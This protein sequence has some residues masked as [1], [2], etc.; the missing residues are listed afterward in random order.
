MGSSSLTQTAHAN[1]GPNRS[2]RLRYANAEDLPSFPSSGLK[3]DGAAAS[4]AASLGWANSKSP[5]LPK[6]HTTSS[7]A[8]AAALLAND[9]KMGPPRDRDP[10]HGQ[11]SS[12][13]S[14]AAILAAGSAN[15]HQHR[16]SEPPSLWGS[17]AAN[18]A[19]K[20]NKTPPPPPTETPTLTQNGS[21]HAAK[22]AMA[23]SRP[24]ALSSPQTPRDLYPDQENA[25]ANALSAATIA[26]RPSMRTSTNPIG[27]AGA[28]PWT[29]M[30][31]QMFTSHPPVKLEVDEQ[32]RSDVIHASAVAM[33]KQMYTQQQKTINNTTRARRSSSFTRQGHGGPANPS[34]EEQQAS[35][36]FGTLQ[37]AAY[38]LAQER[39]AK[40]H[41]E[42]QKSRDYEE[43]YG[44]PGIPQRSKF[45]SIRGK[46]TRRRSASDGDLIEDQRR[47]QQIRQQMSLFNTKVTEVDEQKRTRDRE[48]LLA[49]A[50]R[51][52][53]AQMK[54]MDDK[55]Q[56]ETGRIGSSNMG[57]WE[58][59][60]HAAAQARFDASRIESSRK[61]DIG[62]GKFM[63]KDEVDKIAA[64]RI[65]PLLD[66]INE[67]A[68]RER[69]KIALLKLEEEK[70]K[71]EA[72]RL[73]MREREV[74][75]IHRKLKEQQKDDEKARQAEI[76]QAEKT[77]KEEEKAA[78]AEQKRIA[79][80]AK[81]KDKEAEVSI[82]AAAE[83]ETEAVTK[84]VTDKEASPDNS[85]ETTDIP[86][87][88]VTNEAPA[89][90]GGRSH[91]LS[92]AFPKLQKH[93]HK[94]TPDKAS[95]TS[96][97]EQQTIS[98]TSKV[99]S[100]LKTR[101][102]RPR[103]KSSPVPV[104]PTK[105]ND[106]ELSSKNAE[107]GFIGGV[108]LAKKLN[109]SASSLQ[110]NSETASI[111][112]VAMAGRDEPGESSAAAAR[113]VSPEERDVTRAAAESVSSMSSNNSSSSSLDN[114][115]EARSDLGSGPLTPPRAVL[116][117]P[118]ASV[119]SGRRSPFRESRFSENLE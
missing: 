74:Q 72:E 116:K 108:A 64:Q 28:V 94:D 96:E 7:S 44:S 89:T 37:E 98:P 31:R 79:K 68:E 2:G 54:T 76:K 71:E 43:Y 11:R 19:F 29:T 77:R 30:D 114:F 101:F 63:D 95:P 97:D 25:T 23:G 60:A 78:K 13:G 84:P 86:E 15:R 85:Q 39:L 99:K 110:N 3:K 32:R 92:I 65:Q 41:D 113:P 87:P 48:T 67:K 5:E 51:N 105:N 35:A 82:P 4:V 24:R 34:N 8:S 46:L 50:Q 6:P 49:A 115:Q 10:Q 12:A 73:K 80:D 38:R 112:E 57:D 47:S 33:A 66:E 88:V 70:K 26:H 61:I 81:H 117:V 91:A 20:A 21:M 100:W 55:L 1:D 22:G 119:S 42:H 83:T 16:L 40:L 52:V 27:D 118:T 53:K 14:Q 102:P 103:A 109:G 45:G 69:E 106:E 59:K 58:V 18:L 17:S 75:E 107:T 62:G 111:R 93:K 36:G 90:T 9:N 56:A 104:Q